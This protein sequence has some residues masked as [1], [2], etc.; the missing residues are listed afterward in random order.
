MIWYIIVGTITLIAITLIITSIWEIEA[1]SHYKYDEQGPDKADAR[2]LDEWKTNQ[3]L[4]IEALKAKYK[5]EWERDIKYYTEHGR[6]EPVNATLDDLKYHNLPCKR[7]YTRKIQL[8]S[9]WHEEPRAI[10]GFVIGGLCLIVLGGMIGPNVSCK[11]TWAVQEQTAKYEERITKLENNKQYILTYYTY[12][13][14]KDIDIS[15]TNIPAVIKEHNNEVEELAQK[16]KV[17]TINLNNP[18]VSPWVNPACKNIDLKQIVGDPND[19]TDT[20]LY[21]SKL[22]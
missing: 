16:I 17:D 13:V 18:W 10:A 9:Y 6:S 12:G 14:S 15:S 20:G 11:T 3:D 5:E 19:P 2:N 4:I 21:I 1:T 7:Y 8:R 22:S